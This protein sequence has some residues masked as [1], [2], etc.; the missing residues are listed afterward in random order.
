MVTLRLPMLVA[1]VQVRDPG[2]RPGLM[3]MGRWVWSAA[4]FAGRLPVA[5]SAPQKYGKLT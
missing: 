4:D 3:G 5:A 2:A 1:R